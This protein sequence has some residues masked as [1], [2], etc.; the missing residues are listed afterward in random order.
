[1]TQIIRELLTRPVRDDVAVDLDHK[2]AHTIATCGGGLEVCAAGPESL[3]REA[4]NAVAR[5]AVAKGMQLG[6]VKC[7]TELYSV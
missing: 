7:H 1:M 5:I 2:R 4:K 3:I 6:R